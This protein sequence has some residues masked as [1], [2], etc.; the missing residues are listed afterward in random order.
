MPSCGRLNFVRHFFHIHVM[1]KTV[2]ISEMTQ[3]ANA[4]LS[5]M[6]KNVKNTRSHLD[7]ISITRDAKQTIYAGA[8]TVGITKAPDI[9]EGMSVTRRVEMIEYAALGTPEGRY[10]STVNS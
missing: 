1:T 6:I 4:I 2:Q 3:E 8:G 5:A 7:G 10:R 9:R